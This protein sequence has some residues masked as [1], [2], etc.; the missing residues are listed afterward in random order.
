MIFCRN[1]QLQGKGFLSPSCDTVI[2]AF[3][4]HIVSS[5]SSAGSTD[6]AQA[7]FSSESTSVALEPETFVTAVPV[8][9]SKS[10]YMKSDQFPPEVSNKVNLSARTGENNRPTSRLRHPA[11]SVPGPSTA[12]TTTS[13]SSGSSS[14]RSRSRSTGKTEQNGPKETRNPLANVR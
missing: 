7:P 12:T 10:T 3:S 8:K 13:T 9:P 4:T 14:S 6:P 5:A 11:S 2:S 1:I